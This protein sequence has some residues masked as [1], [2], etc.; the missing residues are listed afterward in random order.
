MKLLQQINTS[1]FYWLVMAVGA[2]SLEGVALYY[3]YAIGE[4]P[5]VVCIQVRIWV[6]A[7]IIIGFVGAAVREKPIALR[8]MNI[9]SVITSVGLFE[10]SYYLLG[11]ERL[12]D[13]DGSCEMTAGLPWWFDL[14][15]WFPAIFEVKMPC[16]FTPYIFF[17]ISMAEILFVISISAVLATLALTVSG[18]IRRN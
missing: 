14:E 13:L 12:W 17:K 6:M 3:Q 2:I 9:L 8:S 7:Y 11:V 5:C 4:E 15:K 10:R 1:I 18:F 16:G